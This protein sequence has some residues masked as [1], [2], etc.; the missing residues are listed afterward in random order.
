MHITREGKILGDPRVWHP[1]RAQEYEGKKFKNVATGDLELPED[2]A[3]RQR[4]E[5]QRQA[6]AGL[7]ALMKEVLGDKVEKA[8]APLGTPAKTHVG[9]T[10]MKVACRPVHAGKRCRKRVVR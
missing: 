5:E 9:L 6:F 7:C 3:E 2:E 1:A 4:L 8:C 10:R